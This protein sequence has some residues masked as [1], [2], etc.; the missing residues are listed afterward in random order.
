[1]FKNLLWFI[2]RLP[3][4]SYL[5]T[6]NN[7]TIIRCAQPL[8]GISGS[9]SQFDEAYVECLRLAKFLSPGTFIT[10]GLNQ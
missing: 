7:A 2:F 8:V 3:V 9:R 4:L 1:M 10:F 6:P 5:Y